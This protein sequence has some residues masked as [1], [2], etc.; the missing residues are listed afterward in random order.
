MAISLINKT[1][2]SICNKELKGNEQIFY[3]PSFVQ[4]TKDSFYEFNDSSFHTKCLHEH[5][6]GEKAIRFADEFIIKTRPENRICVVGRNLI[7]DFE[8][9]IF[10][11][12]LTSNERENLY[13]FNFLT[14]DKNNLKIWTD[15]NIF[16]DAALKYKAEGKWGDLSTFDYLGYLIEKIRG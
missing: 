11:D 3:F 5:R 13:E 15:K 6:L 8:N 14:L 9:Y 4:N 7:R 10:I 2:C 1:V 12:L 16:L